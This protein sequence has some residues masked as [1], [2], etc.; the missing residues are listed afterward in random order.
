MPQLKRA[1]Q[2]AYQ[3]IQRSIQEHIR[4]QNLKPGD[5]I[6][7]E[8][9]LARIHRVSLMTAR[10]ALIGLE[11]QGLVERRRGSGTFVAIPRVEYTN[12]FS[13]TELMVSR[14]LSV[15]SRIL[16]KTIV[17]DQPEIAARLGLAVH[18]P[19]VKLERLREVEGQPLAIETA[20]LPAE[21]FGEMAR[22]PLERGSL[23][24]TL[25]QTY[26][27]KLAYADEELDASVA[28]TRLAS[29]LG[30]KESA[31]ILRIRQLIYSTMGQPAL[32]VLG[33][34]R[35]DRHRVLIRRFRR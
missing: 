17:N 35:S 19:L 5:A 4:R 14:G 11:R 1:K 25:E 13:T 31:P 30:I 33:L 26:Q 21:R 3:K 16:C 34:Y 2:P 10:N 28:D 9:E 22:K 6:S 7:S 15:R 18:S 12:L 27:A 8:R 29:L 20:Y 24:A 32:Y 23:F